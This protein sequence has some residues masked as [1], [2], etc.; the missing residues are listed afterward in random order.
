MEIRDDD[1]ASVVLA[2]EERMTRAEI[3]AALGV[4]EH[5]V[6]EIAS[7]YLPDGAVA[8]RLR[9]LARETAPAEAL[10]ATKLSRKI[11]VAF[12]LTDIVF[13]AVV[14]AVVLLR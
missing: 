2:L 12:V 6:D 13:F 11:I 10:P 8:D 4:R 3:A 1:L 9:S 14:A 7:G 5:D